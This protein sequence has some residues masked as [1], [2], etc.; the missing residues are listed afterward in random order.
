MN[1]PPIEK[2]TAFVTRI[3]NSEPQLAVFRHEVAEAGIQLPAGTVELGEDIKSAV[4]REVAEEVALYEVQ[5]SEKLGKEIYPVR[6]DHCRILWDSALQLYPM[7]GST[8]LSETVNRRDV[9]RLLNISGEF[10]E[11]MVRTGEI[12]WIPKKLS[13]IHI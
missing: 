7:K 3:F 2:V 9:V 1:P 4:L 10:A 12:G 13:L 6:K 8:K 11:I 5:I